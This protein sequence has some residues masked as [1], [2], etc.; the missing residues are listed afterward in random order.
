VLPLEQAA[1]AA[2]PEHAWTGLVMLAG[3]LTL[4]PL[5]VL[6]A[7]AIVPQRRVFFARW[8]FLHLSAVLL[9]A[10]GVAL[11]CGL[12][13][14]R[15]DLGLNEVLA[16]Q[17]ATALGLAAAGVVIVSLARALD[18]AGA[19]ALG[20]SSA[21]NGRAVAAGIAAY[22]LCAPAL[23]GSMLLWPWLF[24]RLGGT[25]AQQA[26]VTTV[27]ELGP[28]E[29]ALLFALAVIVQPAL[30]E[31]VFRAFMQPLFVQNLG[32]RGGVALTSLLFA[33]LHGASAF[34]PVFGLSLLLGGLMLRTQR[35]LSVSVVHALH[36]GLTLLIVILGSQA[37]GS[38]EPEAAGAFL[39][40]P[41][42]P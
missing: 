41:I 39:L 38:L 7:R 34:L 21:G 12:G 2:S 29:I 17:V 26:I 8:R 20:L 9:L 10:I 33:G 32:D 15:L 25:Y 6:A 18:P 31:L 22:V 35:L 3:G 37:S 11:L 5:A 1:E 13:L 24:E 14:L 23:L 40:G 16:S 27:G 42:A 28:R 36:N 30:E 4:T 19:T